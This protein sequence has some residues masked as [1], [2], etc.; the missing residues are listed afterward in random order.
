MSV[1]DNE[2]AEQ[3]GNSQGKRFAQLT[4]VVESNYCKGGSSGKKMLNTRAIGVGGSGFGVVRLFGGSCR[5][6]GALVRGLVARKLGDL[7][8]FV[9]SD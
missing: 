2:D 5:C 1:L 6:M 7:E 3:M 4:A 9:G 8:S